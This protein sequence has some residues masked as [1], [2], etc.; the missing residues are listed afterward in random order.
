MTKNGP[1]HCVKSVLIRSSFWS[2]FSRIQSECRKIRTRKNYV[3]ENCSRS[4][5]VFHY[6][7]HTIGIG[8][9]INIK[10]DRYFTRFVFYA[11]GKIVSLIKPIFITK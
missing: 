7:G 1:I 4:D 10:R 5:L 3:F 8:T 6:Y 9:A 11:I 2:V